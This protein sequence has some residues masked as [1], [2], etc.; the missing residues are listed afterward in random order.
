MVHFWEAEPQ[1][2]GKRIVFRSSLPTV[3]TRVD[4]L[5]H[6]DLLVNLRA[7]QTN[8]N[9]ATFAS[10]L[11]TVHVNLHQAAEHTQVKLWA[12]VVAIKVHPLWQR[13]TRLAKSG[14]WAVWPTSQSV[15]SGRSLPVDKREVHADLLVTVVLSVDANDRI[16]NGSIARRDDCEQAELNDDQ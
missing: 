14:L 3:W 6:R 7:K 8:H 16:K 9:R 2:P 4:Q 1:G 5:Q 13:K 11:L 12:F 15:R 10:L